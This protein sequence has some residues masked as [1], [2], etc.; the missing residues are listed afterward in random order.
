VTP[1]DRA[2]VAHLCADRAGL[3]VDADKVYL[4]E[5][6]LGPVAR[7]EGFG[8]VHEFIGAMRDRDEERLI[9]AGVEAMSPAE[10]AFFRDPQAFGCMVAEVLPALARGREGAT[11]RIWVAACGA[12][13]EVYSLAMALEEIAP[14]GVSLEIFAS[15]L[16]ERRLEKAQAGIYSQFEVQRGLSAHRLV[17]HFEGLEEGF[18]LSPRIR[19]MV[20]WRRANL[21]EDLSRFGQFDLVVCRHQMSHLLDEAR[22]RVLANLQGVLAPGGWLVLGA[23]ETAPALTAAPGHPGFHTR[24]TAARAA[25]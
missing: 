15:D 25:A 12:G 5:N 10:T 14:A 3:R 1:Q 7:R 18:V 20:R 21:M 17:R 9:W 4:L 24:A 8:S 22:P 13:Q 16:C 2:L 23:N 11:L 6:R 19:Q